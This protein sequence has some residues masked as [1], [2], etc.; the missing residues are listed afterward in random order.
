MSKVVK[1]YNVMSDHRSQRQA[2][3]FYVAGAFCQMGR[4][5]RVEVRVILECFHIPSESHKDLA[6]YANTSQSIGLGPGCYNTI[7]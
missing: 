6:K 1:F 3:N 5:R 2:H 4:V 7:L